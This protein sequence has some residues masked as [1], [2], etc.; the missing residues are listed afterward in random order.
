MPKKSKK[1]RYDLSS[2]IGI[3]GITRH[4]V[5]AIVKRVTGNTEHNARSDFEAAKEPIFKMGVGAVMFS[6]FCLF[7]KWPVF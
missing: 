1:A 4:V 5:E 2:E 6:F 7:V 3:R